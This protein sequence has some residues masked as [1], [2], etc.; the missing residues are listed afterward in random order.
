[1][2]SSEPPSPCLT[3]RK[4]SRTPGAIGELQLTDG[5]AATMDRIP[6]YAWFQGARHDCGNPAGLLKASLA[7]CDMDG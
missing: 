7:L 1:M 3:Q 2:G 6:T 4:S 5:I